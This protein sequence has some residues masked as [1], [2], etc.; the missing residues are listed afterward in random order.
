MGFKLT[1]TKKEIEDYVHYWRGVP[2]VGK[3]L[4]NDTKVLTPTGYVRIDELKVGD[5]ICNTYGTVSRV[6]GVY[7]QGL[8]DCYLVMF[9][10]HSSVIASK[11]HLWTVHGADGKRET[12]TTE[13]IHDR[14]TANDEEFFLDPVSMVSTD[15]R[16]T[17]VIDSYDYGLDLVDSIYDDK[18]YYKTFF[19]KN[20]TKY[21]HI[22]EELMFDSFQHRLDLLFGIMC[23]AKVKDGKVRQSFS[24]IEYDGNFIYSLATLCRGLG[25]D[26]CVTGSSDY[27]VTYYFTKGNIFKDKIAQCLSTYFDPDVVEVLMNSEIET[28]I[29]VL[30]KCSEQ[31]ECTCISVDALDEQFIIEGCIP[32]HNTTLFR[33]LVQELYDDPT[34]GVLINVGNEEGTLSIDGINSETVYE[35]DKKED[36]DG[37]RG[38]LQVVDDLI[39]N[40]DE[41]GIK[42]V[43]IDTYDQLINIVEQYVIENESLNAGVEYKSLNQVGGGFGRGKK[44]VLEEISNM[45]ERL[46]RAGYGLVFISHTK[47]KTMTDEE[48]GIEYRQITTNL[49]SDYDSLIANE[50]QIIMVATVDK[51]FEDGVLTGTERNMHFRDNGIVDAGSRFFDMPDKLPISAENYVKAFNHGVESNTPGKKDLKNL[52]PTKSEIKKLGEEIKALIADGKLAP[53][54]VEAVCKK[55]KVGKVSEIKDRQTLEAVRKGVTEV[56]QQEDS[57]A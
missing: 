26:I 53:S 37:N 47:T 32:T 20:E 28:S 19:L 33:D 49:T 5:K 13:D 55:S 6:K 35:W 31:Y 3:A 54:D 45:K 42:L 27:E 12:L 24:A 10:A 36:A 38:F 2:K 22:P 43:A 8:C 29:T 34:K 44:I 16:E 41:Y 39:K 57:V 25:F 50:A 9:G 30:G 46:R 7:P 18:D 21:Y 11:D 1:K 23:K 17:A 14:S 40:K 15:L 52:I 56:A 4:K 51:V 48:T